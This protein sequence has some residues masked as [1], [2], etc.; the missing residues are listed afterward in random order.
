MKALITGGNGLLGTTLARM[1]LEEGYKVSIFDITR[2]NRVLK[3]EEKRKIDF[4]RGDL[5][6]LPHV[7]DVVSKSQPDTIFHV[8]SM[9]SFP[10]DND[11]QS[12]FSVNAVGTFNIL[13]AARI[14]K[15]PKVLYS[16]S[17]STYESDIKGD[18]IDD[19]ALQRPGTV[20]GTFKVFSELLGRFYARKYGIDFRALRFASITGPG[21]KT[22]HI[23]VYTSWA[24]EKSFFGQPFA[25]FVEPNIKCTVIYFKDAARALLMLDKT[26]KEKI[27]TMCY[28]LIGFRISAQ[29]LAERVKAKIP[30]SQLTFEPEEFAMNVHSKKQKLRIDDSKAREEFGWKPEYLIDELIEDFCKV[31]EENRDLYKPA[32]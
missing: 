8:G 16:S 2:D 5:G 9:L 24:I 10:S 31:L 30:G 12:A 29:E 7:M 27:K 25:I 13:E 4:Y 3:E 28:N 6:S 20:Y 18:V 26:P 17:M 21:A 15:V 19:Y 1:L 14:F 23:S 22:K 11:P 32:Y